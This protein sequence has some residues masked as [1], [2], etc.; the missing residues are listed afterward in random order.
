MENIRAVVEM[1]FRDRATAFSGQQIDRYTK[2][3]GDK[4]IT[5]QEGKEC[6][7]DD[8]PKVPAP[9]PVKVLERNWATR[10]KQ[11]ALV[12][13]AGALAIATAAALVSPFDGP[14]GE[15]ALGSSTAATWSAAFAR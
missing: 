14:F 5:M 10:L 8:P 13:A 2:M 4:Y 9:V 1:K 3:F 6:L 7:C 11:V 15:L 12:G